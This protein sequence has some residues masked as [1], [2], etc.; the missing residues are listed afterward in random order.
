MCPSISSG[1][2][3]AYKPR[4]YLKQTSYGFKRFVSR[5]SIANLLCHVANDLRIYKTF[6]RIEGKVSYRKRGN[7][8]RD[9]IGEWGQYEDWEITQI[10]IALESELS[11]AR[12]EQKA[13][14][15]KKKGYFS[16]EVRKSQIEGILRDGLVR[17]TSQIATVLGIAPS[18]HLRDIL[19]ELYRDGIIVGQADNSVANHNIFYWSI[20]KTLPIPFGSLEAINEEKGK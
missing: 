11:N 9:M 12:Y 13:R 16:R 15:K 1:V 17:T 18:G 6:A 20:Q 4:V 5:T 2:L 19:C 14:A 7:M 8:F 3:F 10:V